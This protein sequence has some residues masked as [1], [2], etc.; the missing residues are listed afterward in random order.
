MKIVAMTAVV[1]MAGTVAN[2]ESAGMPAERKVTVCVE[3][4]D[5]PAVAGND[6]KARTL[7]SR[8]FSG[9]GVTIDW[10]R[11]LAGCP[12]QGIQIRVLQETPESLQPGALALARPYEGTHILVFYDRIPGDRN[13]S[14]VPIVLGHVFVHE[15]THILQGFAQHSDS[16]LMKARWTSTDYTNMVWEPLWF[17]AHDIVLIYSGLAMRS[18]GQAEAANALV[19]HVTV[20]GR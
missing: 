11:G 6:L 2:A 1:L 4:M 7:A 16:G 5:T 10:R 13:R 19:S 14:G 15:I 8:I 18:S 12:A 9:I 3:G 17:E 20:A